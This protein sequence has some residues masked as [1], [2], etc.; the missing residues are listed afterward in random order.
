MNTK[1]AVLHIK[2]S[3]GALALVLGTQVAQASPAWQI[4]PSGLGPVGATLVASQLPAG[5]VG[6][7]QATPTSPT[8]FDFFEYGAYRAVLA[9]P[10][11]KEITVTYS[12]TGS[13]DFLN[14]FALHFNTGQIKLFADVNFDFGSSTGVY[15]ADNVISLGS[16]SVV[17]GGRMDNGLVRLNAQLDSG[18]LHSG[19]LLDGA[20]RDLSF[21]RAALI[22][23]AIFNQV[24][25]PDALVV[26]EI[27]CQLSGFAGPGCDGTP[28]S[29]SP[30]AF[31]VSD[32]C[33]IALFSVPEPGSSALMMAGLGL[34]PLV[35]RR[36]RTDAE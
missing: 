19:Y 10:Q 17:D 26:D 14:P 20:G 2:Q 13:G 35:R 8:T 9:G 6:F 22:E 36:R 33:M 29:N 25:V 3:L 16:F 24:S 28:F 31:T 12:V 15:R 4:N 5:G 21:A 1:R 30:F 32:E 7:V 34:I 27:V 11:A 18:T 23:L